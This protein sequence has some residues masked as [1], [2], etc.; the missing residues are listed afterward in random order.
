MSYKYL[1]RFLFI[2]YIIILSIIFLIP[3]DTKII[4]ETIDQKNHP[5]NSKA[6]IIHFFLFF[7]LYVQYYFAYNSRIVFL[8]IILYSVLIEYIQI[9][10]NRGFSLEDIVSNLLGIIFGYILFVFLK[11][12]KNE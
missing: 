8:L 11:F 4:I 2:L 3:L 1:I 7:L 12:I 9:I 5:N 10:T 6:L